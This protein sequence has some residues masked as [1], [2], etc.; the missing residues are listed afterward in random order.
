MAVSSVVPGTEGERLRS[1][2]SVL[3]FYNCV[4]WSPGIPEGSLGPAWGDEGVC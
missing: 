4:L 3:F 2:F 1:V